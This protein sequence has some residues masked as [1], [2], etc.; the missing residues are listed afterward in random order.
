MKLVFRQ[1]LDSLYCLFGTHENSRAL[2]AHQVQWRCNLLAQAVTIAVVF[3]VALQA[4]GE[5]I[6]AFP[7]SGILALIVAAPIVLLVQSRLVVKVLA[8]FVGLPLVV[9]L[10]WA[11]VIW[12]LNPT[13]SS[14][15]EAFWAYAVLMAIP[16]VVG[17]VFFLRLL[18]RYFPRSGS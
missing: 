15:A 8:I 13:A 2:V 14:L 10:T 1:R 3:P 18:R 9:F 5:Q 7:L 4:H 6:M 11:V 12:W 17:C 16:P